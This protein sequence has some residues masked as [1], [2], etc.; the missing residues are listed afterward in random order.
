M[1]FWEMSIDERNDWRGHPVT[2]AYLAE[3]Q[4]QDEAYT[5][6]TL[7]D[8]W[9]S[10]VNDALVTAGKVAGVDRAIRVATDEEAK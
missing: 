1:K 9:G 10:S 7:S 5:A 4:E 2:K 6:E 8:L 3:L